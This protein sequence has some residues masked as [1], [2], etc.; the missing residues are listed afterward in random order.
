VIR[1]NLVDGVATYY[2]AY[3]ALHLA[4]REVLPSALSIAVRAL[5]EN[6]TVD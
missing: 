6:Q 5:T 3:F 2:L 4:H 1:L